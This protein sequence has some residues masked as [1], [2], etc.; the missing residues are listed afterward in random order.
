LANDGDGAASVNTIERRLSGGTTTAH[1]V[2]VLTTTTT[3]TTHYSTHLIQEQTTTQTTV[4]KQ[5]KTKKKKPISIDSE[6]STHT[7]IAHLAHQH[8]RV[9]LVAAQCKAEEHRVAAT[10]RAFLR[11]S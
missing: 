2:V 7:I 6:S 3:T 9:C 8:R 4:D 10:L 5:T 11:H 1:T